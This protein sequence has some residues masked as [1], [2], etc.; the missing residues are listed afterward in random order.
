[1]WIVIK[2]KRWLTTLYKVP[3]RSSQVNWLEAMRNLLEFSH[4]IN[5]LL[6]LLC[7]LWRTMFQRAS[8]LR[9][10]RFL[11]W[12]FFYSLTSSFKRENKKSHTLRIIWICKTLDIESGMFRYDLIYLYIEF[13]TNDNLRRRF[14]ILRVTGIYTLHNQNPRYM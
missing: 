6:R 12:T 10:I 2:K 11:P 7:G 8:L 14:E 3:G 1:M 4:E 9:G 5:E 13:T